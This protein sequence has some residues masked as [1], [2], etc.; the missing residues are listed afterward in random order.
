MAS[1]V[2]ELSIQQEKSQVS[3]SPKLTSPSVKENHITMKFQ[4]INQTAKP[5]FPY[6]ISKGRCAK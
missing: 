4:D 6:S 1:V 3:I 2:K 5:P